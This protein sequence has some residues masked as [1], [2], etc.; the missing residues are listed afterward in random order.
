M[1]SWPQR[2]VRTWFRL[3]R[4]HKVAALCADKCD[5]RRPP[6]HKGHSER[7]ATL[8]WRRSRRTRHGC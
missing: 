8:A 4:K 1:H 3:K 7:S 2:G 6:L 5:G